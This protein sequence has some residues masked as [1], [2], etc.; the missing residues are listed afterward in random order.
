MTSTLRKIEN[1]TCL[2]C[3]C[4]CDDIGVVVDDVRI[5]DTPNACALGAQW[6][7]DGRA[8]SLARVNGR[9]AT[10]DDAV[11]AAVSS[12]EGS[13]RPLVYLAPGISCEAQRAAVA[14]ADLLGSRLDSVSSGTSLPP[15]LSAQERGFASATFG[16]IRNRADVVVFWAIDIDGRYPR[17]ASRYAPDPDGTHVSGGRRSRSVV[18]VDVGGATSARDAD[19]RF[20]LA[21]DDELATITAV[22]GL[23]LGGARAADPHTSDS[24]P[25]W[26]AARE[27]APMLLAAR[28][29]ALVYDAELDDRAARSLQR[30]DALG[31]LAQ[32]LNEHTRCAGV[33]LRAGGNRS[34]ADSVLTSQTGFPLAV[35]FAHG[36]PHYDPHGGAALSV[37]RR[38][39][40]DMV[41]VVGDVSLVPSAVANALDTI[42]CVVIGP[43]ATEAPLGSDSVLIDTGVAGIHSGGTALR[44]DDVPLVLRPPMLGPPP[45]DS[46]VAALAHA[47]ATSRRSRPLAQADR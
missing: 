3:G 8:P 31:S 41:L 4:A 40:V 26:V 22:R 39:E 32:T 5:R 6:F 34:G 27:L 12:L 36:F 9:D 47:L 44:A 7:G 15:V 42:R 24:G 19:R 14:V 35:N 1:V 43:R 30:F 28:Y 25:G 13:D 11:G 38:G 16:E 23:V 37:L 2:G 45:A 29:V 10:V 20:K 18:A 21:P 46:I 33:A 17:F